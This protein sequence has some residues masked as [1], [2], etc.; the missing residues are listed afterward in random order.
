MTCQNFMV[1]WP[2]KLPIRL[3][4]SLF[5]NISRSITKN[6]KHPYS[7]NLYLVK[8]SMIMLSDDSVLFDKCFRDLGNS[9]VSGSIGPE[10]GRLVNLKYL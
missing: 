5:P 8:N 3:G 9:N 1:R 6:T 4:I 7:I 2:P 10:L